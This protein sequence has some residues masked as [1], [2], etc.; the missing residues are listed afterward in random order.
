MKLRGFETWKTK[1]VLLI[2]SESSSDAGVSKIKHR[3]EL[4]HA[5]RC[6]NFVENSEIKY[7]NMLRSINK[8]NLKS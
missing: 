5:V 4:N 6:T 3:Y 8:I 2:S 7:V 1:I